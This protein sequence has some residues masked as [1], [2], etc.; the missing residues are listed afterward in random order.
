M[1]TQEVL[2]LPATTTKHHVPHPLC[3]LTASEISNAASLIRS[4][5][6]SNVT[7]SFKNI[8]LHEPEK[9]KF[10]PYLEAEHSGRSPGQIDRKSFVNYYIKNT[11]VFRVQRGV[12]IGVLGLTFD[13][14]QI[15]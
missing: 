12:A 14:G 11:V 13:T 3:P 5:W 7:L 2:S 6:P 9:K 10:I 4:E 1:A 8:S 15:S